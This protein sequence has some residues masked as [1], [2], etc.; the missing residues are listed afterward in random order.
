MTA[1]RDLITEC[2][3][4]FR[5]ETA[6]HQMTV[7]HDE[8]LYRHLR[9]A[10]PGS[11]LYWFDLVTWPGCLTVGGDIE[12]FA[13][14]RTDDM[15]AFFRAGTGINPSYWAEKIRAGGVPAREYSEDRFR[16]VVTEYA[17]ASAGEYPGLME[18]VDAEI[19]NSGDIYHEDG[20]IRLAADFEYGTKATAKCFCG[21]GFTGSPAMTDAWQL[22][23]K[24]SAP[25]DSGTH[26]V[27]ITL[28]EG[29][30]FHDTWE[31]DLRAWSW[32][33]L[34][35]CHAIK[36]GIGQYDAEANGEHDD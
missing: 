9:F 36:W 28:V 35:A 34:R 5:R 30:R 26:S 14:S 21:N 7:L 8:G 19:F 6:G 1:T 32:H 33:F 25:R 23:H 11:S 4:A 18:A 3:E 22:S 15:F 31:W 17:Q 13:F 2:G 10:T 20:A 16:Q 27:K 29:F 12:A 24:A